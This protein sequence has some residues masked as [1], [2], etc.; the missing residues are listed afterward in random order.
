MTSILVSD[1]YFITHFLF[2]QLLLFP[3]F[4]QRFPQNFCLIIRER[5]CVRKDQYLYLLFVT[6]IASSAAQNDSTSLCFWN[7]FL[8]EFVFVSMLRGFYKN[9]TITLLYLRS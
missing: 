8:T 4:S 7:I 2:L 9:T 1:S 3:L 5:R 6:K